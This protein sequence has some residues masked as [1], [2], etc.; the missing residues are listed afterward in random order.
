[1]G[2]NYLYHYTDLN[3]VLGIIG[4]DSKDLIFWGSRYDCMND[5][6]DYQYSKNLLLPPMLDAAEKV[7][8][9]GKDIPQDAFEKIVT[10][11]Y[12]VSFSKKK[13]DF[14][15]WRMYNAQVALILDKEYFDKPFPNYALIECEYTDNTSNNICN[16]FSKIEGQIDDCLNIYA[17]TARAATFIKEKSF[18]EESEVRLATWNYYD[19]KGNKIL[20]SDCK[21][22]G[23]LIDETIES[24]VNLNGKI[25]LYRKFHVEKNALVGMIIH[26]YS[27][28]EYEIIKNALRTKL[29]SNSYSRE[30]FE[31]II[32]TRAYPFNL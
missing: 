17:N 5:P 24:R 31:N 6:F 19:P 3:A 16:S 20:L 26:T 10:E 8:K 1:M 15:M 21:D 2:N 25:I 9:E 22:D 27:Q 29:I 7:A 11:P 13:D 18:K 12:I 30:V 32:P 23:G 4:S 14:L 28:F